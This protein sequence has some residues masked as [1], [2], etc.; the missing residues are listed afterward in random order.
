MISLILYLYILPKLY[1]KISL[2]IDKDLSKETTITKSFIYI[3][4]S[5]IIYIQKDI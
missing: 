5:L 2:S 4:K 1:N 3:K